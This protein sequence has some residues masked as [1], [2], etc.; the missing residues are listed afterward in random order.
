MVLIYISLITCDVKYLFMCLLATP[1]PFLGKIAFKTFPPFGG[2]PWW[3]QTVKNLPA[4]WEI[5]VQSL[6]QEDPLEEG[7]ATHS[8]IL[9]WRIQWTEEHG[10]LQSLGL[11]R[12][13]YDWTT[14]TFTFL[15]FNWVIFDLYNFFMYSRRLESPLDSKEIKS[16]NPKGNQLWTFIERT[17]AEAEAPI[18]WLPDA[19]S[20]HI[21]KDLDAGKDWGQRRRGKQRMRGLNGIINSV[22]MLLL[23]RGSIMSNSLRPHVLQHASLSCPSTTPRACSNSCPLRLWCHPTISSS[24]V[25]FS[26]CLQSFA[27]SGSLLMNHLYSSGGWSIGVSAS[28]SILSMNTQDWFPL[29]VT[30]LI[31]LLSED[32][33]ESSPT[34]QFKSINSS[35]L[36][37]LYGPTLTSI[38]DYW[39]SH[40]FNYKDLCWQSN[41]SAL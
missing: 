9:V 22:N 12:I 32:S 41:V 8:C 28:I 2:L 24:V 33:Q 30:D 18:L 14:N 3:A 26:S 1:I 31:S 5:Q 37:L 23:F 6:G 35:A 39:K 38:C 11:Q 17:D 15:L 29:G 19:K 7:M 10:G 36:S 16:V 21:G 13:G 25:P 40:S 20:W 27:A 4:M 34:L